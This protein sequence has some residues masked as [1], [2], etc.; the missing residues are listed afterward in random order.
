MK[1]SYFTT[2]FPYKNKPSGEGYPI[3]GAETVVEN[4]ANV[5]AQK[6]HEIS[7]FT[8][9]ASSK[10]E[11]EK[12]NGIAVYRYGTNFKVASGR[13]SFGLLKNPV[14]Y[15][16]DLVH[17]H[18]SVPMG[19]IGGF[20][21]AKRKNKP[22]I[23]TTHF[24]MGSY[25]GIAIKS[26]YYF[27]TK[28]IAKVLSYADVVIS[29]SENYI[30]ESKF[31]KKY[32]N[33]VVVIPNGINIEDF[34][35]PYSKEECREKLAFLPSEKILLYVGNLEPRKGP[36]I[37]IKAMP[38]I[39]KNVYDTKLVIVGD[40]VM[41]NEL[42]NLAEKLKIS[43]RVKFTG[44]VHKSEKVL[45]YK[46]ADVLVLPSLYEVFGIVNLEAMACN[47]PIVASKIGGIPDVVKDGE[48]GL[49]VP[50]RDSE[51]L[52]DAIIYLLK[53]KDIRERMGENGRKLVEEKYTWKKV[54]EETD[55]LYLSLM[56]QKN[57]EH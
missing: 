10:D 40:G 2:H 25:K 26:A 44:F 53:N 36:D 11:I 45:Y 30:N 13:F 23:A 38:R 9:S 41:R 24:D 37:L 21:Y 39:L 3:G 27:Y 56:M 31:I 47:V 55:K 42:N 18:I 32:K 51:A 16:T 20:L 35:I 7:I 52:A 50:P 49:L 15:S 57:N 29:P 14:K 6:G 5:L 46:S 43:E 48:N 4:L 33:K 8:T 22:L 28:L 19:D 17:V 54:A 12:Y 34:D 1:I